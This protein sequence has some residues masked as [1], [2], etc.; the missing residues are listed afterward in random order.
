MKIGI[1]IFTC[2]LILS[3]LP[4]CSDFL[5]E[6]PK[7]FT[8][9]QNLMTSRN[10]VEQAVNGI[11]NAGHGLYTSRNIHLMTTINTDEAWAP[12]YFSG[13]RYEL[14]A[15]AFDP[16]CPP[17]L[18]AYQTYVTAI[19]R[20]NM[21]LDNMPE[22]G[23]LGISDEK[24]FLDYK[25]G[26]AL[27]L[28]AWYYFKH[29]ST[30]GPVP[31]ITSFNEFDLYPSNSTI[32]EIYDQVI[33][34]LT[35]AEVLLPNWQDG[36][37]EAGRA[38]RG[39]AKS[40]LGMVY[41]T[42]ATS[43]ARGTNDFQLAASKLKEVIDQ[44]GYDLWDNYADAFIPA[45]KN[46]K[47]DIFSQQA[48]ANTSF[49]S[50]MYSEFVPHPAPTGA[51]RAYALAAIT[52]TLYNSYQAEDKRLGIY[53]SGDYIIRSTGVKQTAVYPYHFHEKYVDPVN[54][55]L[56]YN[57]HSTNM[58]L[59]RYADVLLCYSEAV[60]EANNGPN[61]EAYYGINKVRTRAGIA[62]LSGLGKQQFFEEIVMERAR[63]LFCE[64]IRWFDLKR[65]GL[66]KKAE[67]RGETGV[68]IDNVRVELPKHSVFPFPQV[69]MDAN[70]NLKQNVGY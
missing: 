51:S 58:P 48:Q 60:N 42:R 1:K 69:E 43:E 55:P 59:I 27:F 22:V 31:L 26:E 49:P 5:D 24:R 29:M 64:G 37:A 25:K 41:L 17:I 47:E 33:A 20:A 32:P 23:R 67:N 28:R 50:V 63:E 6:T 57:N 62:P 35:A 36:I 14:M 16:T 7:T 11:Y 10:G 39:A 52:N 54:G 18:S 70:P 3:A 56:S 38:S 68:N 15:Y 8:D 21:V 40:L 44:E 45:H 19:N 9:P 12:L 30:F 65:W 34:D 13:E 66:L 4:G 61:E 2:L 46:Q 53:I